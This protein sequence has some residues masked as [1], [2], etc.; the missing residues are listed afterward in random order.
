MSFGNIS[1]VSDLWP[2]RWLCLQKLRVRNC[3]V[4]NGRL[5]LEKRELLKHTFTPALSSPPR[6]IT[7]ISFCFKLEFLFVPL[8]KGSLLSAKAME[9]SNWI[10]GTL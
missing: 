3:F 9:L 10:A 6:K 1:A 2:R 7:A 5:G 8:L 4:H